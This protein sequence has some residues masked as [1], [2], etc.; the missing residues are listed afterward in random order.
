MV[1]MGCFDAYH[2]IGEFQLIFIPWFWQDEYIKRLPDNFEIM[3]DEKAYKDEFNLNEEQIYWRR[4]KIIQLGGNHI[5]RMEYPAT[6]EE[7][8]HNDKPNALWQRNIINQNRILKANL[9]ELVRIV[10]AI[11]PAI[12]SNVKSNETGIIVAGLGVDGHGYILEDLSSNYKPSA[13]AKTAIAA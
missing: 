11:D 4:L 5:F 1:Q 12:S 9:P 10:V 8:F 2:E 13:W 6:V 3:I 7:A